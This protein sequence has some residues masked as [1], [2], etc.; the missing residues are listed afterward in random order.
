MD[1]PVTLFPGRDRLAIIPEPTGLFA[2]AKTTGIVE[3][4]CRIAGTAAP[5]DTITS[6]LSRASSVAIS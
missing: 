2:N 1:K 5:P 3:V 6:T 4:A